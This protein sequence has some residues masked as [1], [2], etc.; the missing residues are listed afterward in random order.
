M[1]VHLLLY[2]IYPLKKSALKFNSR[3]ILKNNLSATLLKLIS[4][5]VRDRGL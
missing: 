4:K 2:K 5:I 1:E 3:I